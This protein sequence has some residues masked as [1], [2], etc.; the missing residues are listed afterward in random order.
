DQERVLGPDHSDTLVNR[1]NIAWLTG[2]SGD[3]REGLRLARELLPDQERVLGLD[4][5]DTLKTR[6]TIRA[7]VDG[8]IG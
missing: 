2:Q 4:H 5:P 8:L 3:V 1:G 7:R 6:E